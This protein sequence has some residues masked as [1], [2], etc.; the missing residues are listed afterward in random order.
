MLTANLTRNQLRVVVCLVLTLVTAALYWPMIHHDFVNFDD[1]AYITKNLHVPSGLTVPGFVWAF[2]TGYAGNWHPLTWL[3]HMLDCQLYGL[4]PAGHHFTN[5]LFHIANTLLLFL[6]LNRLSGAVWRSALV[7]ALF[8]WHPLHVESVAWAAERKDVLSAFF[9]MLTLMAYTRYAQKR[10]SFEGREE[11][12]NIQHPTSNIQ[13]PIIRGIADRASLCYLASLF[14]FAC[15]LMSKPM[16]VT[17]P[18]VLLLLDFWPLNRFSRFQFQVSSSEKHST[19]INRG[20]AL[21]VQRSTESAFRLVCEKLPF[22]AL[23]LAGSIVTYL[24]QKSAGAV[25]SAEVVPFPS[26]VANAL[27]AYVRYISKSFWP[28]D[29]AVL[30]P[31]HSHSPAGLVMGAALMLA[32]WSGLFLWRARRNPYLF[33]GW[34][35]F[36]G[37][38]V[39]TIGLVQVGVQSMA[40]RYLYLPSIGLFILVAWSLNDL[41]DFRPPW[42]HVVTFAGIA[43]LAGCLMV[44][45]IQLGYW[46]NSITLLRHTIAVTTDNYT[47]YNSLGGLLQQAG[48][49]DE[50]LMLYAE[51]ARIEP[52]YSPAQYNL[53]NALLNR[54]WTEKACAALAAAVRLAPDDVEARYSF[55]RALM[56]DRRLDDAVAQFTEALG[57]KPDFAKAQTGLALALI[58]QGKTAEAI[59]HFSEAARLQPNDPEARFNLGLALL[60]S[61]QPADAAVQL[62][63]ELRLE[64]DETKAHY[65]LAQALQQQNQPADAVR[66]YRE[67]LRLTPEFPGAKKELDEIL[68]AH[69]ELR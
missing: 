40:D 5:L 65:R 35:W 63:G 12:G 45:R 31:Y 28:V 23:A 38:L 9:W 25:W 34:F 16:V 32:M 58:K 14:F 4:N 29:L 62:A 56:N 27:L 61:H 30:Y 54:G 48:Q 26:H 36:L 3:S 49:P 20:Q 21:N 17:L 7:A 1:E 52:R 13:H 8:A 18:F 15:G 2:Q 11:D 44:T 60:D 39:P 41:V 53:G 50:A 59:L 43:A 66:H 22:F 24:V 19:P 47:I 68:A 10:S 42:R 64:P 33:V 57:L 67:A 69:P 55:G 46:Q 37:T 51:S 6:L